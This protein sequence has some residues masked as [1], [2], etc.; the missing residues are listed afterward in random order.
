MLLVCFDLTVVTK[1]ILF[2][3]FWFILPIFSD[4]FVIGEKFEYKIR[5]GFVTLGRSSM[6][7][8]GIKNYGRTKCLI[9]Q[10]KAIG[11]PW[12]NSFFPVND[13]IISHWEPIQMK[14]YYSEKNLNEGN[15]HRHHKIYYD[16][17]KKIANYKQKKFSGNT[18]K[19]GELRK[20]AKWVFKN[21]ITKNLPD[22]FQD[23]LSAIYF[24]RA[25]STKGEPGKVFYINLYDDLKI[26]KLKMVI[27]KR[28]SV[29]L[30][31]NEKKTKFHAIIVQ[32][33]IKTTGIFRA[34]GDMFLW[35]SDDRKRIPLKI[36][37][38][39][40]YVGKVEV[41]LNKMQ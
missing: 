24:N 21:G 30:E 17:I 2:I 38:S 7:I 31:V 12:I 40:P 18:N 4:P 22:D 39:V 33:F 35:I 14:P 3:F 29:V 23:I 16:P 20:D 26:T 25:N 19:K 34:K 5:W 9:L 13:E 10:T 36:T 11:S 27:L 1:W 41:E 28:E 37:S 32:P 6:S 8:I 15:Y